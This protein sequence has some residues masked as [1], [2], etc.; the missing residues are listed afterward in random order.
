MYLYPLPTEKEEE[1]EE[2]GSVSGSQALL[3]VKSYF[4]HPEE[5][6]GDQRDSLRGKSGCMHSRVKQCIKFVKYR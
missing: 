3:E 4:T 5:A 2:T 6:M 1:E